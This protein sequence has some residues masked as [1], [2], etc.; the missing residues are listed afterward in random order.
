MS[1][2]NKLEKTKKDRIKIDKGILMNSALTVGV[3]RCEIRGSHYKT[4]V[5]INYLEQA[6]KSLKELDIQ[7]VTLVLSE[8]KP[9]VMGNMEKKSKYLYGIFIAPL[10]EK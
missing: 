4:S 7:R 5:N 3:G 1:K 10:V 6:V 2:R 8:N 9:L